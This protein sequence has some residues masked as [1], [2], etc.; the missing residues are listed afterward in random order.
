[1]FC[2]L[3]FQFLKSSLLIPLCLVDPAEQLTAYSSATTASPA[4]QPHADLVTSPAPRQ[5]LAYQ[6]LFLLSTR[7]VRAQLVLVWNLRGR[8]WPPG[9][10]WFEGT[11]LARGDKPGLPFNS[12]GAFCSAQQS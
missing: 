4:T 9:L 2:S 8:V 3:H 10:T 1:M 6:N 5:P 7:L 11:C 12:F